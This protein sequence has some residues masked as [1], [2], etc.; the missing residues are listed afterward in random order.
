MGVKFVFFYCLCY[1]I[2]YTLPFCEQNESGS[3]KNDDKNLKKCGKKG[4]FK[5]VFAFLTFLFF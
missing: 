2:V 3:W 5:P 4:R 1:F